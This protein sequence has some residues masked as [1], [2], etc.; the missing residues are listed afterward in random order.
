MPDNIEQIAAE[1]LA[2]AEINLPAAL[3]R[4]EKEREK[5]L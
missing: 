1:I 4:L 5:D 2:L 3:V